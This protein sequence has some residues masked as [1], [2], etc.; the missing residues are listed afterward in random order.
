M[1]TYDIGFSGE[2]RDTCKHSLEVKMVF[3]SLAK[4]YKFYTYVLT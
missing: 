1:S 3:Y 2:M 4:K